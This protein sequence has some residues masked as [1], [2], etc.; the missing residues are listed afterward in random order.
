MEKV[1]Q[2]SK[3]KNRKKVGTC[4]G[5]AN[6]FTGY[7]KHIP[8]FIQEATIA[9]IHRMAKNSMKKLLSYY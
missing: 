8:Q 2:G 9:F 3:Q 7:D 5:S 4:M 1:P 6:E